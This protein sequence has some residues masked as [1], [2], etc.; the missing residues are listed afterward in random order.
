MEFEKQLYELIR[1]GA[2]GEGTGVSLS[3]ETKLVEDLGYDSLSL[4]KLCLVIEEV[5]DFEMDDVDMIGSITVGHLIDICF[6]AV[7][8]KTV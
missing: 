4:I 7:K 1:K 8:V 6:Q 3:R 5:F 2:R